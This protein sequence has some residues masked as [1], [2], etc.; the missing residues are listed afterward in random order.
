MS[1]IRHRRVCSSERVPTAGNPSLMACSLIRQQRVRA[2]GR[3]AQ[4]SRMLLCSGSTA[5]PSCLQHCIKS[6]SWIKSTY[7]FKIMAITVICCKNTCPSFTEG[8]CCTMC[9][10]RGC[11]PFLITDTKWSSLTG[12]TPDSSCPWNT[13]CCRQGE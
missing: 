8:I 5:Q 4:M 12:P 1:L 10:T 6:R 3:H 9:G 2:G 7:L 11:A 13:L